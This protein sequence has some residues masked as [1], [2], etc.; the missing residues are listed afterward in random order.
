[1]SARNPW[2]LDEALERDGLTFDTGHVPRPTSPSIEGESDHLHVAHPDCQRDG[3]WLIAWCGIAP[4]WSGRRD[5]EPSTDEGR[6]LCAACVAAVLSPAGCPV[7]H[8][9]AEAL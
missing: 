8:T 2:A 9:P 4:D 7:C 1:M 3:E 6:E 5:T